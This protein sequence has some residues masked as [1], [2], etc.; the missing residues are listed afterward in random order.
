MENAQMLDTKHIKINAIINLVSKLMTALIV[1][2]FAKSIIT[3]YGD[4]VN[5]IVR[6]TT[7]ITGYFTIADAGVAA[8]VSQRLYKVIMV[9]N[10]DEIIRIMSASKKMFKYISLIFI[11][12]A[13]VISLIYP[14][15]IERNQVIDYQFTIALLIILSIK[16]I[17]R[18]LW[19]M[20]YD[21]ILTNTQRGYV[22]KVVTF[23]MDLF[24][25]ALATV[26]LWVNKPILHDIALNGKNITILSN[27]YE[28]Y[29]WF[30]ILALSLPALSD[31]F[32]A[33]VMHRIC[34]K[35][36]PW[37]K[38]IYVP[39][40]QTKELWKNARYTLA[41]HITW[42]IV[43]STDE[44]VLTIYSHKVG[45]TYSMYLISLLSFYGMIVS[46][47]RST[48]EGVFS[49]MM[50][51]LG[52]KT[53]GEENVDG[54]TFKLYYLNVISSSLFITLALIVATPIFVQVF[55]ASNKGS[56]YFDIKLASIISLNC[57]LYLTMTPYKVLF[58][59]KGHFK[60]LLLPN[61]IEAIINLGGSLIVVW[62]FGL[63]G[64]LIVTTIAMVYFFI[65]ISFSARR[66]IND[67]NPLWHTIMMLFVMLLASVFISIG[68]IVPGYIGKVDLSILKAMLIIGATGTISLI[69]IAITAL[70]TKKKVGNKN[71]IK[72]NK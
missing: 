2:A 58:Y 40:S 29:K 39:W 69:G 19:T 50:P 3:F 34:K 48:M 26:V 43:F 15:F 68:F 16:L 21:I 33:F 12:L 71:I 28:N 10:K 42:L 70:L 6:S 46:T 51:Y 41:S 72:N 61:V 31:F 60:R 64:I 49:S 55:F 9:N 22:Y 37:L 59:I 7:M 11:G 30:I 44:I 25:Y 13:T 20:H 47:I 8:I 23:F 66:Y 1:F 62:F 38:F 52:L 63:Y 57:F 65:H 27:G 17:P 14:L 56:D 18:Y 67:V 24:F 54:K 45:A 35:K 53:K 36:F 32:I 5:G 4:E